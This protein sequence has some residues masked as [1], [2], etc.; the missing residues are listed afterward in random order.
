[1]KNITTS[2][3]LTLTTSGSFRALLIGSGAQLQRSM[4]GV[5]VRG[6]TSHAVNY[7]PLIETG[8]DLTVEGGQD[9][10]T[11]ST[12]G[13]SSTGIYMVVFFGENNYTTS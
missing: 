6:G 3:P 8:S 5:I 2:S 11:I 12:S 1:M 10:L 4:L 9:I 13:T 7:Y